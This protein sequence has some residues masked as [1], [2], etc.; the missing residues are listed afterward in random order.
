MELKGI[1]DVEL[2]DDDE[3]RVIY[4]SNILYADHIVQLESEEEAKG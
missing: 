2:T 4:S 1:Y 3:G